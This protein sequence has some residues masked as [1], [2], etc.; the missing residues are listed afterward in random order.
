MAAPN[1][2]TVTNIVG[3]TSFRL[4]TTS[5]TSIVTNSTSSNK[6]LKLNS[7]YCTNVSANTSDITVSI[8]RSGSL[9]SLAYKI[10]VPVSATLNVITKDTGVYLEE[11]DELQVHSSITSTVMCSCSYEEIS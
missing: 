4:A 7:L 6:L 5:N 1:I 3:K 10:I 9:N 11:G 2:V 8:L